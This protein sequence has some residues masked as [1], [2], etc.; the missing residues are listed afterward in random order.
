[1]PQTSGLKLLEEREGTGTP[2]KTGDRT[3]YNTRIF[4]NQGEEG[5]LNGLQAKQLPNEMVRAEAGPHSAITASC[6]GRVR[7]LP[8]LSMC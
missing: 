2:A 6:L 8:E 7:R 1:M 5:P 3:V 4:L